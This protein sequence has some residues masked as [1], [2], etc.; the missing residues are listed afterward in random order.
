MLRAN[1]NKNT[2]RQKE[3]PKGRQTQT[4][5][6]LKSILQ[7]TETLPAPPARLRLRTERIPFMA[8][9]AG[10]CTAYH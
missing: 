9:A 4:L 5:S 8:A 1:I 3:V 2:R 10:V 6:L 7:K